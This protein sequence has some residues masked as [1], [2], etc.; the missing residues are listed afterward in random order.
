[1]EYHVQP[2]KYFKH[3]DVKIYCATN[4]FPELNFL[5]PHNKPHSIHRYGK[6]Y[7]MRFDNK[8]GHGTYAI[9][10]IPCD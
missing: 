4:Q 8:L 3:Q 6:N 1:M 9:H 10:C 7:H 5:G 2:N